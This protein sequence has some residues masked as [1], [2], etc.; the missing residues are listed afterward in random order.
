MGC[1]VRSGSCSDAPHAPVGGPEVAEEP[2][3]GFCPIANQF[4][5]GGV[6]VRVREMWMLGAGL[7]WFCGPAHAAPF[8]DGPRGNEYDHGASS[9]QLEHGLAVEGRWVIRRHLEG[10]GR[11]L[12][13]GIERHLPPGIEKKGDFVP[14]GFVKKDYVLRTRLVEKGA[15]ASPTDQPGAP[16]PEPAGLVL[17]GSGL[18]LAGASRRWR[19]RS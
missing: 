12:P 11:H 3:S 15:F 5:K 8:R 4:E 17:F 10:F 18:L 9:L 19:R 7:F 13:L 16:I 14:P 1:A 6:A 2:A